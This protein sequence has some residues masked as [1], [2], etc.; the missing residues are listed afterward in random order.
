[1]PRI[2]VADDDPALCQTLAEVLDGAGYAVA[3]QGDIS[4]FQ[5][6]VSARPLPGCPLPWVPLVKP[7][8]LA[9]LMS[10]IDQALAE[11]P[12]PVRIGRWRFDPVDR[13]LDD[14]DGTRLRLTDKEA[15]ILTLLLDADGVV[16]RD[17]LLAKV[18]GYGDGI[19]THTLETHVYRLRQKIED[20]PAQATLLL[21]ETGGYRLKRES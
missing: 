10:A 8:R 2:L 19:D 18:W 20:D 17:E 7:V 12:S 11:A 15:A 16:G 21:T 5:V 9:A 1:M 14:Q 4:Q 6:V 13:S 3:A